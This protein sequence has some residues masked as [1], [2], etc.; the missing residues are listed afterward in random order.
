MSTETKRRNKDVAGY[1][2]L[3]I[4]AEIDEDFNAEEGYVISQYMEKMFPIGGNLEGAIEELSTT[5]RE[6][7]PLLFQRAAEDFYS[8]STE[9]ERLDFIQFAME[10]I[11]ADQEVDV[12]ENWL[13]NKLY[14]YWDL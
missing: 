7:Y 10:L 2:L 12:N 8:D 13:I 6:N 3:N 14:T 11:Q 1:L 9:Q 4:L 5:P